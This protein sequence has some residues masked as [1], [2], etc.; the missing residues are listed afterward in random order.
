M[1][2]SDDNV[3]RH[4]IVDTKQDSQ[5]GEVEN[6][7]EPFVGQCFL[8]EEEAYKQGCQTRESTQTRGAFVD[9]TCRLDS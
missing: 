5:E 9:S 6:C 1:I 7:F 4:D 8:S 3:I 2:G